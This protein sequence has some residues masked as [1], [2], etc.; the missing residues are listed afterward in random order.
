MMIKNWWRIVLIIGATG[1]LFAFAAG[2]IGAYPPFQSGYDFTVYLPLVAKDYDPTWSWGEPITLTL[3]PSYQKIL[4]SIDRQGQV[5]LFWHPS[6]SPKFIYH[7]YLAPSGWTS[8]TVVAYSLGSSEVLH[9]PLVAPDGVIHLLWLNQET[10]NKPRR[11]LYAT[12]TDKKWT[13]EEEVFQASNLYHYLDGMVHTDTS[14]LIHATMIECYLSCYPYHTVRR[15]VWQPAIKIELPEHVK[16]I[17]PDQRGG[18]HFY[19]NDYS[20]PR[21][22]Y[23][24]YW[25]NGQFLIR[26]RFVG[27]LDLRN[28]DTQLDGR[29]NLHIFWKDWVSVPGGQV[30]GLY[31]QCLSQDLTLSSVEVLSG[32]SSVN[33]LVKGAGFFGW[34]ALA[35][36]ETERDVMR[37]RIGV[38]DGCSRIYLKTCP[39]GNEWKDLLAVAVSENPGK[40]CVLGRRSYFPDILELVCAQIQR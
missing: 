24:S 10:S 27:H 32:Q 40:V 38:W 39:K 19:G 8:P 36:Q 3:T 29:N 23:Y 12:F 5:H 6:L 13:S 4:M 35:W 17:W 34:V 18:V 21:K 33:K 26:D 2:L 14:G 7:A 25:Q 22:L 28:K 11:L 20:T 30:I 37:L 1:A 31:Y 15:G 9:P 16:W